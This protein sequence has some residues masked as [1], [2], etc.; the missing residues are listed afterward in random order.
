MEVES[1]DKAF[2]ERSLGVEVC[3][4]IGITVRNHELCDKPSEFDR[5]P[6][7][8]LVLVGFRE[9]C[10]EG[11]DCLKRGLIYRDLSSTS[12]M[13]NEGSASS[14]RDSILRQCSRSFVTAS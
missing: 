8:F 3:S 12:C 13:L 1:G 11:A 6:M 7:A 9:N 4:F 10:A 14:S 5:E 2:E